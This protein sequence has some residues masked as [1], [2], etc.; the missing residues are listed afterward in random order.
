MNTLFKQSMIDM[1]IGD[2]G[3]KLLPYRCTADKLTIGIGR[4]LEDRGI[5]HEEALYL[6]K[7]D[8]AGVAA[9]LQEN[10]PCYAGLSDS[11]RMVLINMGFN[12]GITGLLKF[13]QML[14]A[15]EQGDYKSAANEML[16]S[17]WARQVHGRAIRLAAIMQTGDLN[18][19]RI[20]T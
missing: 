10:L 20:A 1:L 9:A 4:N 13:K 14:V 15:L 8:I 6:C 11:R 2:E 7:N 18:V 19:G 5:S 3:L 12:L 17:A 16:D